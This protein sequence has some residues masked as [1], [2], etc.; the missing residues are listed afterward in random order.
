MEG[1]DIQRALCAKE[2]GELRAKVDFAE[3]WRAEQRMALSNIQREVEKLTGNGNRGRIDDLFSGISDIKTMLVS[4]ITEAEARD[5]RIDLHDRRI[6]TLEGRVYKV[7][8]AAA[9]AAAVLVP[10]IRALIDH[11]Y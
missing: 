4:H 6:D 2:F 8:I 10:L 9:A 7:A 3:E 11:L 5:R 1:H